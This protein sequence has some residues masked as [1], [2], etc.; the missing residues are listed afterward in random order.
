[1]LT[2]I[3]IA[4]DP[5]FRF[6]APLAL[7]LATLLPFTVIDAFADAVVGVTVTEVTAYATLA[8]YCWVEALNAGVSVAA[9]SWRFDKVGIGSGVTSARV[10]VTV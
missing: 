4:L 6:N 7:P 2:A 1:L 8:V 9:E 5:T 10:T 3:V